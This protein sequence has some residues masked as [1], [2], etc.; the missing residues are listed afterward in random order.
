M[1]VVTNCGPLVPVANA[2]IE[3]TDT[4]VG[5][6]ASYK[7]QLGTKYT[8]GDLNRTC[9]SNKRWSGIIPECECLCFMKSA[10][11]PLTL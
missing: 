8:G 5:S 7:C 6:M 1:L 3:V 11:I 4:K 2:D 9:Q 10:T